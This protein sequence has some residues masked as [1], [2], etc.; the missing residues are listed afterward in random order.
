MASNQPKTTYSNTLPIYTPSP[1]LIIKLTVIL[2]YRD[3]VTQDEK[4]ISVTDS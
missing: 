1:H 4:A 3:L 2:Y